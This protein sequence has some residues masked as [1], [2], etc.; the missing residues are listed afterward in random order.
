MSNPL[1]KRGREVDRERG[2]QKII[3][4]QSKIRPP[5]PPFKRGE[6][7]SKIGNWAIA[8]LKPKQ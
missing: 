7:K 8:L 2:K 6:I 1:R 4:P 3:N 5:L